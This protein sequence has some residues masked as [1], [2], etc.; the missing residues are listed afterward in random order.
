MMK[1]NKRLCVFCGAKSGKSDIYSAETRQ[2]GQRLAEHQIEII[3][4]GGQIGLMGTLA[5]AC[6]E[7]GGKV[8]GV[9]PK[10]LINKEVLHPNLSELIIVNTMQERKRTMKELSQ[11]FLALPGGLGTV[12]ELFEMW[13]LSQLGRHNNPL[14]IYDINRYFANILGFFQHAQTEGFISPEEPFPMITND[15]NTLIQSILK[16]I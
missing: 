11:G 3:F 12:E 4:G 5:N 16:K 8:I 2:L 7:A 15:L 9:I 6:L 14:F 13:T 10:F 1:K